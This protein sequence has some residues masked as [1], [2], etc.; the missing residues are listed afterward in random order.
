MWN[1][2]QDR[3]QFT[4]MGF[5]AF[6]IHYLIFFTDIVEVRQDIDIMDN[7]EDA[8]DD[9]EDDHYDSETDWETDSKFNYLRNSGVSERTAWL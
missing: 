1:D 2:E 9:D 6:T 7:A 5:N 8:N 4:L 3:A